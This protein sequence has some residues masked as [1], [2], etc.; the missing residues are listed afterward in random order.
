MHASKLKFAVTFALVAVPFCAT[1]THGENMSGSFDGWH[2]VG[3]ANW[4]IENGEFVATEGNGHLVTDK[5]YQDFRITAEFYVDVPTANSGIYFHITDLAQIR[6]TTAYEANINDERAD[7]EKS[8]G[9]LVNHMAP[10]EYIAT[11][12]KWNTYDVTIQ[13]DH[14]VLILNGVTTVDT[15]NSTHPNAGP[16]SLQHLAGEV[17]FRNVNI[18]AL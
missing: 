12:G 11:A 8:T 16:V 3:N 7:M 4:S 14:I 9:A 6:D 15:H 17:R 5:S 10:S 18:E 1:V 2:Q 13:G